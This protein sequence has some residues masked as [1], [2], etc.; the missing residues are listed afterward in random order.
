MGPR[1][2]AILFVSLVAFGVWF[3]RA[4]MASYSGEFD[5]LQ[6][7]SKLPVELMSVK[8]FVAAQY[9]LDGVGL[10]IRSDEATYYTNGR[11]VL[12][13]NV[14]YQDYDA[15]GEP[16]LALLSKRAIGQ[17]QLT[18]GGASLFDSEKKL[19]RVTFPGAVT[20]V[21]GADDRIFTE[22][23]DVDFVRALATTDA[24]VRLEGPG[25]K[26]LGHG[27]SYRMDKQDFRLGGRVTGE[28]TPPQRPSSSPSRPAQKLRPQENHKSGIN[29]N[30]EATQ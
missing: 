6:E 25:R 12:N 1:L 18:S 26:M 20:V 10:R 17:L 22:K 2:F 23:V 7:G 11:V 29:V 21:F 27:F 13:G 5:A 28:L 4:Y 14:S 30:G 19:E 15:Q 9:G 3:Q 8:P 16:R 24:D